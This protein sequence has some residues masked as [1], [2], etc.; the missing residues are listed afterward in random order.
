MNVEHYILNLANR[1]FVKFMLVDREKTKFNL[2][3]KL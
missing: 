3:R 1:R 2:K